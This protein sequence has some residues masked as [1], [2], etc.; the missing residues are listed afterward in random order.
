MLHFPC[1][2]L[3]LSMQISFLSD[4]SKMFYLAYMISEGTKPT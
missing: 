2:F 1:A 3:I 4:V